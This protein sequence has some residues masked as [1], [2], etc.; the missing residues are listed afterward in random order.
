[1]K[2]G[3][4][5]VIVLAAAALIIVTY[6]LVNRSPVKINYYKVLCLGDSLTESSYGRYTRGLRR[7]FKAENLKVNVYSAAKPGNT[8]G[9]YLAYLKEPNILKKIN[10]HIIVLMLGTNDVRIDGDHTPLDGFKKNMGEI[11]AIIKNYENPGGMGA[12]I[13]LATIPPIFNCDLPTFDETSQRRVGEEIVPAIKE[14]AKEEN[15]HLIDL[16]AFFEKKPELLPGVHPG[17]EGYRAMAEII[18][19]NIRPYIK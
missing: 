8:S 2:R 10:P 4:L 9:E 19:S 6:F 5:I 12:N 16:F 15:I 13:F 18:F 14:L 3:L 11:I 17:Q 7:L 1:M